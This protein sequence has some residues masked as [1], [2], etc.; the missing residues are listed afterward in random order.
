M[1]EDEEE[2]EDEEDKNNVNFNSKHQLIV[3][4]KKSAQID[5]IKE[6]IKQLESM[7]Q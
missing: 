3:E 4:P 5:V 7:K 6:Q 1:E 2:D